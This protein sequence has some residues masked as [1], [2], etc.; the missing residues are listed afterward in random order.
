MFVCIY[1]YIPLSALNSC[2]NVIMN[3][4]H[5]HH[6]QQKKKLLKEEKNTGRVI[7]RDI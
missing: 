5:Y 2:Y 6:F 1:I 4:D 7:K 3:S